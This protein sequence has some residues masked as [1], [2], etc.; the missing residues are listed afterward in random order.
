MLMFELTELNS[1]RLMRQF[2]YEGCANS[3]LFICMTLKSGL[4]NYLDRSSEPTLQL[5]ERTIALDP[6][7]H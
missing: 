3:K 1:Y 5:Q 4:A 6:T 2:M 7:I